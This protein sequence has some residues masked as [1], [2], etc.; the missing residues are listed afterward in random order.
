MQSF[1]QEH[2]MIEVNGKNCRVRVIAHSIA[3]HVTN[4]K[5]IL[6]LELRYWRAIHAELMTHRDFSRNAGSSRAIPTARLIKQVREEPAGPLHWGKNQ[7]GMQAR[8]EHDALVDL[9]FYEEFDNP[10]D[11]P[12]FKFDTVQVSAQNAWKD[13]AQEA[14]NRAETFAKAGYHKQIVNRLL[15]PFQWINVL[16]TSTEWD[17]W[18]NLRAHE[19][20]QPEIQD[21]AVTMREAR[22]QSKPVKRGI[23][24]REER[25]WHLPYVLDSEREFIRLDVLKKLST[26]RCAR[27]SYDP[28]DGNAA[29]E[30]E[31]ERYNMLVGSVPL[32]ASPT[33]HQACPLTAG[34][35][36]SRNFKGW[37]QH[38]VNV[39]AE[40]YLAK[41][42]A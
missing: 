10:S 19:D 39:E 38:R 25:A 14:A 40:A 5:E 24:R 31:I 9:D 16:V 3:D 34:D 11:V 33:E 41:R 4:K 1:N 30:K 2:T 15:E 22:R 20:A 13:A 27:V 18:D 35:E 36:R 37:H 21:L 6:T 7:P 29:I 12:L 17:N 28:F 26:A 8:E 42:A 32:H 23:E